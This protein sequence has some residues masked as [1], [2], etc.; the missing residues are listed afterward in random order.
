M[1]KAEQNKALYQAPAPAALAPQPRMQLH[2]N[3]DPSAAMWL[4]STCL[5]YQQHTHDPAFSISPDLHRLDVPHLRR[6]TFN[7]L[8]SLHN[9]AQQIAHLCMRTCCTCAHCYLK[10]TPAEGRTSYKSG[11][12][13]S[14]PA[15]IPPK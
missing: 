14:K 5:L 7:N 9:T 3:A 6:Q 11:G 15:S 12:A 1:L 4:D 2:N 13:A 10:T 8:C